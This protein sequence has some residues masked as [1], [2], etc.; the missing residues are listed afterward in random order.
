[1]RR[2]TVF[3]VMLPLVILLGILAPTTTMSL[4]LSCPNGSERG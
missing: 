4:Q 2:N 3:C 1:M